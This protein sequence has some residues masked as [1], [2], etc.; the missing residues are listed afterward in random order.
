[1]KGRKP[2]TRIGQIPEVEKLALTL[3]IPISDAMA[4]WKK[5]EKLSGF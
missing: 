5:R 1:M 3:Q 2:Y 4:N